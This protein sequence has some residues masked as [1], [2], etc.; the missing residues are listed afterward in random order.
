VATERFTFRLPAAANN[1]HPCH[2]ERPLAAV[3]GEIAQRVIGR[4]LVECPLVFFV[5]EWGAARGR[6]NKPIGG[7][8]ATSG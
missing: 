5:A 7:M 3:A 4:E 2:R 1:L 6:L 8:A